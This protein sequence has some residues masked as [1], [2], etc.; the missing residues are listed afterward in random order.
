MNITMCL[1]LDGIIITWNREWELGHMWD[2]EHNTGRRASQ[3]V[4][5]THSWE[6]EHNKRLVSGNATVRGSERSTKPA[7]TR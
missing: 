2:G 3:E 6:S 5:G 7:S 4:N 1:M